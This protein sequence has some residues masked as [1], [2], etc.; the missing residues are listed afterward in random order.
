MA[1]YTFNTEGLNFYIWWNGVKGNRFT[2]LSEKKLK[3][4]KTWNHGIQ[5]IRHQAAKDSN[6]TQGEQVR[7][8]LQLLHLKR[9]YCLG[10]FP[11]VVQGRNLGR[12]QG[13]PSFEDME[14]DVQG[15]LRRWNL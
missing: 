13:C 12:A 4:G 14:L 15:G 7:Q 3:I 1:I 11:D 10:C 2:I 8:I 9:A 6:P 5:K